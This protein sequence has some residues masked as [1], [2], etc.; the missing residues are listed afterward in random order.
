MAG[1]LISQ[2]SALIFLVFLST[3]ALAHGEDKPG[4][5]GGHVR[6]P[7][8]FHTELLQDSS[9]FT[10]KIYLSDVHFGNVDNKTSELS[11]KALTSSG[12]VELSCQKVETFFQCSAPLP[13]GV[14]ASELRV[15]SKYKDQPRA[16]AIYKLPLKPFK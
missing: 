3:S 1:T 7:A 11:A 9:A 6:M 10:F 12:D 16:T 13:S 8:S 2:L 15:N 4:P 5:H 14:V